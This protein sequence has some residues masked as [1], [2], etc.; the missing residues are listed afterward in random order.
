MSAHDDD[1]DDEIQTTVG[2]A[3][4]GASSEA[5]QTFPGFLV[6]DPEFASG[7]R[8]YYVKRQKPGQPPRRM[9]FR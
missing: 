7:W 8:Y 5:E 1:E 4:A 2:R 6:P 3:D 9:G